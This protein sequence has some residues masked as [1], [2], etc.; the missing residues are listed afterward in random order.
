MDTESLKSLLWLLVWDG[1]FYFMMRR[2]CGTHM[3]GGHDG[4][5]RGSH[6]GA[7]PGG[8]VK[9]PV[10]GM[11]VVPKNAARIHLAELAGFFPRVDRGVSLRHLHQPD[12]RASAQRLR[13]AVV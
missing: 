1:L 7:G 13:I 9:D 6:G 3:M 10:C 11:N 4:H 2:G 8:E 12:F 5:G